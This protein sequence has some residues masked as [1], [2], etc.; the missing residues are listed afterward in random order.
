MPGELFFRK[1]KSPFET[2]DVVN[3]RIREHQL[4]LSAVTPAFS[5]SDA[6]TATEAGFDPLH[7]GIV[8]SLNVAIALIT[9]PMDACL[10]VVA[11]VGRVKRTSMTALVGID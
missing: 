2:K 7:F 9:P 5:D 8:M 3:V 11:A 10:F 1:G 6:P 4:G